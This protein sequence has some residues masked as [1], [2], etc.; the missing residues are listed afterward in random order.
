MLP[1]LIAIQAFV[2]FGLQPALASDRLALVT[3][4]D[5]PPFVDAREAGGGMAVQ[6]VQQ[7]LQRMRLTATIDIAPWRRGYEE[8]LRG[9]YDAT[10][11]YIRTAQRERDFLYSDALFHVRPVVFMPANRRFAYRSA[12]DLKGRRLCMALG[13][14]APPW[15]QEMVD[16]NEVE[17]VSANSGAACPS[18]LEADRADFFI[19]DQRIGLA[20]IAK[21][22]L[23]RAIVAVSD[24]P[25][26]TS[27][28][29]LIVPRNRAGAA[30][31]IAQFNAAL[32]KTKS[33]GDY[34]RLLMQ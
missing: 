6:L 26:A 20:M 30:E 1:V 7:V 14:A 15:L 5:Y 4:E 32:A 24:P 31:L 22:G 3:G 19:Q 29:H 13:Y 33:S 28:I 18:M 34:D 10:F 27:D 9:R 2:L 8:T 21:A 25:V 23:S 16:R 17:K 12:A 11:P